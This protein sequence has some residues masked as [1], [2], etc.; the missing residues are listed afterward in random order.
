MN[1]LLDDAAAWWQGAQLAIDMI[2]VAD[3]L[4]EMSLDGQNREGRPQK[5]VVAPYLRQLRAIG[6]PRVELAFAAV[7]EYLASAEAGVVTDHEF[8]Q[9]PARVP[10]ATEV[11]S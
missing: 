8:L 10:V 11:P 3:D 2:E 4:D 5:N 6:D 1:A 7:T 9:E